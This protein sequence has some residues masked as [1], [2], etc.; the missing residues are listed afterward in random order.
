[1][2]FEGFGKIFGLVS[3]RV[4]GEEKGTESSWCGSLCGE[5]E[6]AETD[7]DKPWQ[8]PAPW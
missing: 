6:P 1:M 5:W 3:D 7:G 2:Y 8:R 4:P